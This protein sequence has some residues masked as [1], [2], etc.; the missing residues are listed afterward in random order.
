LVH[1]AVVDH[2][3]VV[4]RELTCVISNIMH[5]IL[6][7]WLS[8]SFDS[9]EIVNFAHQKL[10]YL[11]VLVLVVVVLVLAVVVV[12]IVVPDVPVERGG[13]SRKLPA[14][15]KTSAIILSRVTSPLLLL[16]I[17]TFESS[18]EYDGRDS[19]MVLS[20]VWL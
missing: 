4:L 11:F 2:W 8:V 12:V 9:N 1:V 19:S 15:H 5:R 6:D 7:F 17:R 20:S 14:N 10:L 3:K 16:I 18:S 13:G